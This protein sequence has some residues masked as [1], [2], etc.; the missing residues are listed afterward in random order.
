MGISFTDIGSFANGVNKASDKDD[1]ATFADRKAELQADR[2]MH[3]D[4]KTKR[5]ESELKS[6]EAEDKKFKAISAVNA[7]FKGSKNEI[8]PS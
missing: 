7:K 1:A 8:A 6:F 5:Y 4:M 3:I 2:Q